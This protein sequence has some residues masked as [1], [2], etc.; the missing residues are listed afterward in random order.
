MG[1]YEHFKYSRG[2]GCDTLIVIAAAVSA[3]TVWIIRPLVKE[4]TG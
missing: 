2:S 1:K 4:R 3:F